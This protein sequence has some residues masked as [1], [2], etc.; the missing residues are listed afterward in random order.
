MRNLEILRGTSIMMSGGTPRHLA[1]VIANGQVT[2]RLDYIPFVH[3]P[4]SGTESRENFEKSLNA[5]YEKIEKA[6][7]KQLK[8]KDSNSNFVISYNQLYTLDDIRKTSKI[9]YCK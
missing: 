3:K 8:R 1:Q 5:H 9:Q 4:K 7:D 2:N 6:I